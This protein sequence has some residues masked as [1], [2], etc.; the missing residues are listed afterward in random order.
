MIQVCG[1]NERAQMQDYRGL[2]MKTEDDKL[3]WTQQLNYTEMRT[4]VRDRQWQDH[5]REET[6]D[7][8]T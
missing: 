1:Y 6:K 8:N 3:N 4:H 2:I 7:L 5:G